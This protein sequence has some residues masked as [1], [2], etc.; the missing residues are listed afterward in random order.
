M[1]SGDQVRRTSSPGRHS[2][3]ARGAFDVLLVD[4][5]PAAAAGLDDVARR[6]AEV[7]RV[8]DRAQ[9]LVVAIGDRFVQLAESDLLGPDADLEGAEALGQRARDADGR[10]VGEAADRMAV[11]RP[12]GPCRDEVA[13]PEEPGDEAGLRPLVEALRVGQLLVAALVHH[14]DAIGHRHRL[15]LVVGHVDERDPDLLLDALELDLHLLAE[16]EVERA[17]GLVEQQDRRP[18]DERPRERDA[19]GLAAGDLGRLAALEARQLDELEHV[20]RRGS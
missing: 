14:G 18:V 15:L 7:G 5:E 1:W 10:A 2:S 9:Q 6:D 16:L 3:R 12:V 19:L 4:G 17:E 11:I 13:D 8:P 20:A